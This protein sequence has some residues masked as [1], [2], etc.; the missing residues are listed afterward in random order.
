VLLQSSNLSTTG[1]IGILI[2]HIN[3][4]DMWF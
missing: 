2:K 4:Q 3:S 1:F